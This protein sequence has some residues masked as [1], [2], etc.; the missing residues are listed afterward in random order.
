MVELVRVRR[1][2]VVML[3]LGGVLL[4]WAQVRLAVGYRRRR[5]L[6][7]AQRSLEAVRRLRPLRRRGLLRRKVL[8]AA[9]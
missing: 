3:G 2:L 7:V 6:L 9:R 8:L 1:R 4:L 5:L